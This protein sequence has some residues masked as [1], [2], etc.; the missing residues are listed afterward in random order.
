M[1]YFNVKNGLTAGNITLDSTS[2]NIN[3]TNLS[4]TGNSRLGNISNINITGGSTGQ[5][6][7]TDGQGNL[8][9]TTVQVTQSSSPMPTYVAEGNTLLIPSN[10]QGLFGY[11]ITI[12]GDLEVDGVLYDVTSSG[13][14]GTTGTLQYKNQGDFDSVYTTNFANGILSL[15]SNSNVS[16][17]GGSNGQILTTDGKGNLSWTNTVGASGPSETLISLTITGNTSL[18]NVSNISIL[19]GTANSV[20]S[21]DGIGNLNWEPATRARARAMTM[22]ILLG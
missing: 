1:K 16:I 13:P 4:V 10:F 6:I 5:V 21:T 20:L 11:P 12:D 2:G 7:S 22:S 8:T 14:V 3:G 15:G 17:T 9:F 18:G 19:G